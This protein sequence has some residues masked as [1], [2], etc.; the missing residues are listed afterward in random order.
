M[1]DAPPLHVMDWVGP[2]VGAVVFVLVMSLVKEPA[3]RRFNAIFVAGAS[4]VYL[5]GGFGPWELLYPAI[6]APVVYLGLRS[7]RCIGFAWLMHSGWD[8]AHHFW[9]NPIW[10]FMPTSSFG[11]MIFD[12]VIAIWFLAGAPSVFEG[13]LHG[14]GTG[15]SPSVVSG[16]K[17][18]AG[19]AS[20]SAQ[21]TSSDREERGV[22]DPDTPRDGGEDH[23]SEE[24]R[25]SRFEQRHGRSLASPTRP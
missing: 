24:E 22:G 13:V 17:N 3:R 4:G 25:Q 8:V 5:S 15:T 2:A 18:P 16:W 10:P 1:Y 11:C 7:H 21:S 14:R 6:T 12:L 20:S 23:R 9:G 19:A